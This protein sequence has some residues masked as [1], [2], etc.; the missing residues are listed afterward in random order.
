MRVLPYF[1]L[2]FTSEIA[3]SQQ[4]GR[5]QRAIFDSIIVT[6]EI[7]YGEADFYDA[8]SNH[9]LDPLYLDFYEP[10]DDTLGKRPLVIT[11][12]GGGFLGGHKQWDDMIAWCDSLSHYG[13]ACASIQYRLLFNPFNQES[14]IR[15]S[16]RAVQDTRAAIRFLV[17]NSGTYKIDADKIFLIGNSA[18][19]ITSLL[20]AFISK[21]SERPSS[22]Y[23]SG[24]AS[25]TDDLGCLDCSGNSF[26]HEVKLAGIIPLWG[27]VWNTN[28]IEPDENI[29]TL[30]IHGTADGTVPYDTGYAFNTTLSPFVYGSV[31][32]D[33]RM[34]ELG[35][36]HEFHPFDTLGHS[37]YMDDGGF[38]FPNQYWEPV[39]TLGHQFLYKLITKT[40]ITGTSE[41]SRSTIS[42]LPNPAFDKIVVQ[43][44][45][46]AF[47]ITLDLFSMQG[48]KIKSWQLVSERSIDLSSISTG[49]YIITGRN[50]NVFFSEKIIIY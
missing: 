18:G 42:I 8:N 46:D 50:N 49:I 26:N 43:A 20:T 17:E 11:I 3:N 38:T 47:P 10:Y 30:L 22:T 12:F 19:A 2:L 23:G 36:P 28:W 29:P 4:S 1:L 39:F 14:I 27:G 25:D 15:A 13:Y 24:S 21:D 40:F 33:R 37:F 9:D 48:I 16:Y 44:S 41:I 45:S 31:P 6:K 34:A 7:Q 35:I 5:Y 32:I